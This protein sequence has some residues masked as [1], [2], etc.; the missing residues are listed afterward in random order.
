M[1]HSTAR[2]TLFKSPTTVYAPTTVLEREG[3]T[4]CVL[5]TSHVWASEPRNSGLVQPLSTFQRRGTDTSGVRLPRLEDPE[6]RRPLRVWALRLL[7]GGI[8][9]GAFVAVTEANLAEGLLV[10][11]LYTIGATAFIAFVRWRG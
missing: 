3:P 11:T 6:P 1:T 5:Q 9:I 2:R 8:A 10:M 7:G 4:F